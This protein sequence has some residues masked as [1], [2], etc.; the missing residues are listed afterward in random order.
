M[1]GPTQ[2]PEEGLFWMHE[3]CVPVVPYVMTLMLT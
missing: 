2:N 3:R 1:D